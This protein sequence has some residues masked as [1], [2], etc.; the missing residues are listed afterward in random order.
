MGVGLPLKIDPLARS[1]YHGAHARVLV[2]VDFTQ[3][4][5]EKVLKKMFDKDNTIDIIFFVLIHYE[6]LL[7][8]CTVGR[9]FLP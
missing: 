9:I 4:L 7:K 3:S 6:K 5:P 2:S 8:F 1:S